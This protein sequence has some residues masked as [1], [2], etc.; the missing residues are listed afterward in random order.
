MK[1]IL[2]PLIIFLTALPVFSKDNRLGIPDS[3][4]I[5][6]K[7]TETWFEAPLSTLREKE[8]EIRRNDIGEEFQIRLEEN[9]STF[10]IF[11]SP[12]AKINVTVYDDRGSYVMEQDIYPGDAAGSVVFIRDKKNGQILRIRYYFAK[13]ADVYVQFTPYGKVGLADLIIYGNYA[14]KGVPTGVPFKKFYSYSIEDVFKITQDKLPWNYVLTDTSLYHSVQQM[15]AVIQEKLPSIVYTPLAIYDENNNLVRLDNGKDFSNSENLDEDKLYLSSAGFLKWIADGLVEPLS[16]GRLKREP[17]IQ[18][19][20]ENNPTGLQGVLSQ[21]N[22]LSFSLDWIRN[23]SSAII[24]VNSG[25]TYTYKNSFTDVKINPF[26]TKLTDK[27]IENIVTFAEDSGYT[28]GV[29]KSILYVLAASEPGEF[30]F[31]AIRESDRSVSPEIKVFNENVV[32]F[33]YF[34]EDGKF[35]CAVFMNGRQLE[36]DNFLTYYANDFVYL[37]RV[38]S[39]EQF[40]PR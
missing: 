29:L 2:L 33:P 7:L 17:L 16:G 40:F 20:V 26:S 27:G 22:S 34:R 36:L 19:T 4:E 18:E 12:H 8:A 11:V 30:Y 1:K 3:A 38:K 15:I 35:E 28:S 6:E 39:S 37:T 13:D 25:N 23:L 32:F 24:S 21:K 5:R 10:N 9:D 31:G 14:A